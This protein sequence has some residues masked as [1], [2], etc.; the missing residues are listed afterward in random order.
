[1][2]LFL[3][4]YSRLILEWTSGQEG[5]FNNHS[6]YLGEEYSL[7]SGHGQCIFQSQRERER[8]REMREEVPA[9]YI[10]RSYRLDGVN[11]ETTHQNLV[12]SFDLH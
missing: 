12:T 2:L 11:E 10:A 7:I 1:M 8:E 9:S 6:F 3:L 4:N 5:I